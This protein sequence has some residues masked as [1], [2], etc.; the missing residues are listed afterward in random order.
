MTG[1]NP[2]LAP[3]YIIGAVFG[4]GMLLNAV[5]KVNGR[6][7]TTWRGTTYRGL[8]CEDVAAQSR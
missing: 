2:W 4:L 8:R 5:L 6:T 1:A 7:T 3:T